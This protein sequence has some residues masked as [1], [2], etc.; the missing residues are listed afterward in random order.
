MGDSRNGATHIIS[1]EHSD[2]AEKPDV[3]IWKSL[4][5]LAP[6]SDR[7]I[8][9]LRPEEFQKDLGNF[10]KESI[11]VM[12]LAPDVRSVVA[13]QRWD[14]LL[15]AQSGGGEEAMLPYLLLNSFDAS[16]SF[17]LELR[18]RVA[19]KFGKRL[20]PITIRQDQQMSH[21]LAQGMTIIDYAPGSPVTEDLYRLADWLW[22][23]ASAPKLEG[24]RMS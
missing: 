13:L 11:S 14:S 16:N 6:D 15:K 22:A 12:T 10:F 18:D 3:W 7:I 4:D 5:N 2:P 17:H 24:G 23:Q 20:L 21:A 8:V 19:T 1:K 9:D